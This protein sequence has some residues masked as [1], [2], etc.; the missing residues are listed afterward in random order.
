MTLPSAVEP[1]LP[2]SGNNRI[3]IAGGILALLVLLIVAMK[4]RGPAS[5]PGNS[6]HDDAHAVA[7]A[8]TDAFSSASA[9]ALKATMDKGEE[10]FHACVMCHG[11]TGEGISGQYPPLKDSPFV[12]GS[13]DRLAR[14]LLH[15][16][17]GPTIVLGKEYDM[18]MP[19]APLNDDE[20]VAAVM[21]FIRRSF[22]NRASQVSP[23]AIAKV[24]E[25]TGARD[26]PW[27]VQELEGVR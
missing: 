12:L 18:P 17:E 24:R 26:T 15:G 27:T 1:Q 8:S 2:T 5:I 16:L 25:A 22:G 11:A 23:E 20:E 10:L 9:A 13:P 21:T 6:A 4:P 14:I 3:I 7:T 19:A